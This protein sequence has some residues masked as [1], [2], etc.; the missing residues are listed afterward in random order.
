MQFDTNRL[1]LNWMA[2][3]QQPVKTI[4]WELYNQLSD[5]QILDDSIVD[6]CKCLSAE[7]LLDSV[8]TLPESQLQHF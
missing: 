3:D 8:Q 5:K 6:Y 1:Q 2:S 4:F 7:D